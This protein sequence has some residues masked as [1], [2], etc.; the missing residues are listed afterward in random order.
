[1]SKIKPSQEIIDGNQAAAYSAYQTNEVCA[2]YPIT[3]SSTMGELADQWA[4]EKKPN[5]WG[6]IPHVIEMQSEGGAA[7]ALHGSLQAGAL[8]TTFT[9]SQGLLLMIPSMYKIAGEL[10]PTVF[11]IAARSLSA[12]ALSIF[13]DHNDV[14]SV[15]DTG[16]ASLASSNV[17]EAHDLALIAQATTLESRVPFIHFFDG[18]RTSHEL[19]K[20][21]MIPD[22]VFKKM[23]DD[24][25]ILAHRKRGLTSEAPVVRGTTQNPDVYF[26]GR[27]SVNRYYH[28][29]P[30]ILEKAMNRF[31]EL[32]GRKYH[33]VN[34]V[35]DPNA[36]RVIVIMGSGAEATQEAVDYLN[37]RG[38]KIGVVKVHLFHP[39]PSELFLKLLPAS[40]KAIAVLDRTKEPGSLGEPL[41][42]NVATTF[43]DAFHQGKVKS[44][45]KI[46]GGRYGLSSK[47]F[48]P[49]M[50]KGIFDELSKKEPKNR[51]TIGIIDDVTH[52]SLSYDPTFNTE[53]KGVHRAIFYG[54]GADGTVGAN[55]NTIKIIGENTDL[56][57]QG[58]FVYDS[59]KSGARTVSHLRFGPHPIHSTYLITQA[60]FVA[61]HLFQDMKTIDVLHR[62]AEGATFLLNSPYSAEEVWDHLPRIAQAHLIQKKLKFYVIDA[63]KLADKLG[64]GFRINTIM[65]TCFFKIANVIPAELALEKIKE[66]IHKTYGRKGDAMVKLNMSAVDQALNHLQEVKI[67][68]KVTSTSDLI[69]G[70]TDDAPD[71]VKKV[72]RK[73]MLDLGDEIPVS[74]FPD[75]GT[76]PT[77]TT[78]WEKRNI[79]HYVPCWDPEICIQCGLCAMVCPHAVI[80]AKKYDKA[81]LKNAPAS[82]KSVHPR[83]SKDPNEYYTLQYYVEDCTGCGMCVQNCP[84]KNK[85]CEGKKAINMALKEPMLAGEQEN[86]K[87]F[88]TLPE[89]EVSES[90]MSYMRD[91]QYMTPLF[92]FS[93]ACAGC[94]ETPYL[95]LLSQLYGDRMLIAN[96]TG[97]SSIYG[98]NLPT[99]PWTTNKNG[100]GPAWNNSLFEDCAEFGLGFRLAEDK[101]QEDAIHLLHLLQDKIGKELVDN[102]VGAKQETQAEFKAQRERIAILKEKLQSIDDSKAT[103]LHSIANHLLKHS[104]W[105]IGGD[106]WAYDIGFGGLDHVIAS[107]RN[108]NLLVLDTQVYSNTGGQSSKATPLGAVAKFAFDGKKTP[109]KDLGLIAMSYGYVYVTQIAMGANPTHAV[110]AIQ[111]AE[112]YDGPSLIIAYSH[113]IAHVFDLRLGMDHQKLAVN[114]GVWPLYRYNPALV[115]EGK[116]P[117]QLDSKAPS[118]PVEEYQ[119]LEMRFKILEE[120]DPE[121]A[122]RL[123]KQN[124]AEVHRRWKHYEHLAGEKFDDESMK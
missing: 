71:F 47:E 75:D 44:I 81:C 106:G 79:S 27:E 89:T 76:F 21:N 39:F 48:T 111:E 68:N 40:V 116:N 84:A 123:L 80:R 108:I 24:R 86:I 7:A 110:R 52:T 103:L 2:I 20:I 74:D 112:A 33:L 42:L 26:Q 102:L 46:I 114:A 36:E 38:E 13:G 88:E 117:F 53:G 12:Q 50:V 69:S 60:N 115:R 57:V 58:Y 30:G 70:I 14:M 66:S 96:A 97:C 82:F 9:A 4:A 15:R 101:H 37:E 63:Y 1:M 41:Y 34:Y 65:Q 18:F 104:I 85:E 61:C 56:H 45:P 120:L 98:G 83:A 5:M 43:A 55:K 77:G 11:H 105:S 93:G 64:M 109:K 73:L 32:T 107:G 122:A 90:N 99:T 23:I 54:L 118:I 8:T 67:P 94:G 87:F 49:A 16:F 124:Q 92:E 51:F 121:T 28:A 100:C 78:K 62:A 6:T 119:N 95:K 31:E 25:W 29:L 113:C 10:T 91:I 17:Q 19:Q 59:K 72:T 3:P 35:G 22:D